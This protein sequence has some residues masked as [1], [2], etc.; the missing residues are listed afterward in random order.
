MKNSNRFAVLAGITITACAVIGTPAI[1]APTPA[2]VA[3]PAQ[4]G[5]DA[6]TIK[7]AVVMPRTGPV[8]PFYV[9]FDSG[10]QLRVDQENSKGG[11]FGR[12]IVLTTYDDQSNGALQPSIEAK[13]IGSDGNWGMII[14][15]GAETM[16]PALKA[17]NVPVVG[18]ANTNPFGTD[19]NAFG[20][21]GAPAFTVSST[22]GAEKLKLAGATKIAVINGVSASSNSSGNAAWA[23]LPLVG[24]EQSLRIADAP[25]GAFD[26]TA[27]ALRLKQAG[28]DGIL[29]TAVTDTGISVLQALKN[30]NYPMKAIS[31]PGATDPMVLKQVGNL[32]EG[33]YSS[34]TSTPL[35]V[36]KPAIRTFVNAM[37]A[38]GVNPFL[39]F[40]ASGY[41]SADLMVKGLKL[42]GKCPT[43]ESFISN[44]RKITNFNGGGLI[45]API[46]FAPGLTPNGDPA[47]CSWFMQVKNGVAIA[48]PAA[49]CGKLF[50]VKS[51]KLV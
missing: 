6:K 11:I 28:V 37:Q 13:A 2:P 43:R 41:I 38:R 7:V 16:F 26:A 14:A 29:F 10:V 36:K 23:S 40:P 27:V 35:T 39:F 42:A 5:I 45:P 24:L 31:L 20:A 15:S 22:V 33:V 50:D 8:A 25:A 21:S 44:T 46:S 4:P 19:R 48:D 34:S 18:P 17:G 30:Q 51:G 1:G 47:K 49:T 9:A 12:K 32:F 3:C